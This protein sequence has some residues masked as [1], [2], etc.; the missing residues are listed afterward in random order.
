[1]VQGLRVRVVPEA[2]SASA[3]RGWRRVIHRIGSMHF[4]GRID[5]GGR[6]GAIGFGRRGSWTELLGHP[7]LEAPEAARA[8]QNFDGQ[9][10]SRE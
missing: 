8:G 7:L 9:K 10:H 4:G 3:A 6:I 2:R 5:F 1:M